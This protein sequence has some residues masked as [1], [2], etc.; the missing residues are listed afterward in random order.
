MISIIIP[1]YNSQKYLAMC[2]ESI[3]AQTYS[4]FEIL[5]IDD[6]SKDTSPSIC[7]E[8][9]LQDPRVRV[10]H[11]QNGGISSARNEGLNLA[12]GEWVTFC[13]NDDQV[14]PHWLERM[15]LLA[16]E[17]TLPMCAFTRQIEDLGKQKMIKSMMAEEMVSA[18]LYLEYYK[19]RLG[20]FVWNA[21]FRRNIIEQH[22]LRFPERK[23]Q[24][25]INEDLIF[26]LQ[27]LPYVK[28]IAYTGYADYY[29][30]SNESNHSKETAQKFYFEK[31]E[32]KYSLWR[33]YIYKYVSTDL[34]NEQMKQIATFHLYELL[35]SILSS[36]TYL[37]MKQRVCHPTVQECI[38]MAE[39]PESDRKVVWL[40]KHKMTIILWYL[41]KH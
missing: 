40:V 18:G 21:L 27:Y 38:R 7:D 33:D 35:Q 13:D 41:F 34:Q 12:R 17:Y 16:D 31:Y 11:K 36:P 10:L 26:D 1:V 9:S 30:A 6:G 32:E 8:L 28:K 3:L 19:Q 2:V 25:D 37:V 15:S 5:L 24:G 20:G 22:H 14:S 23:L 4:D 39:V 29:W